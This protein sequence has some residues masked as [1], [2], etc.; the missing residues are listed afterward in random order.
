MHATIGAVSAG[1]QQFLLHIARNLDVFGNLGY[2]YVIEAQ[3]VGTSECI[4]TDVRMD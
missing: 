1:V 3:S 4:E 2:K